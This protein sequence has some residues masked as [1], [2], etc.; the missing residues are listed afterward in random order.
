MATKPTAWPVVLTIAGSDSGGGAGVQADLKTF[1]SLHVFG[2][3]A[4]TCLTAQN[5]DKVEGVR[6][7]VPEMVALQIRTV[8]EGFPVLAAKTGMLYS[9]AI[10]RSVS[11]TV[12]ACRVT[13]LVVDPV[14]V[15]TSGA[16][17]LRQEAVDALEKDLLPK[18]TV[19]TPNLPEAEV[20]WGHRIKT[21]DDL[22]TA[23]EF[24]SKR[25]RTA[26]VVKGGHLPEQDAGARVGSVLDVLCIDGACLIVKSAR[27][28]AQETHG[29]G[30]TFSAAFAAFLAHGKSVPEAFKLSKAFVGEALKKAVAVGRHW[31]LNW[32]AAAP[33]F[34]K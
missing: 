30:C 11:R 18:A 13:P 6:E 34:R 22:K 25:Y 27:V 1:H 28:A 29:T 15:A 19:I 9:A 14:M 32:S 16:R 17:L 23:A 21:V 12:D 8:C 4:I 24:I 26:C 2:T 31:P 33:A 20:L 3:S 5:P 10:I 7:V